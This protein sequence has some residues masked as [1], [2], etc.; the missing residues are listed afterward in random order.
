ML[1]DDDGE[2]KKGRGRTGTSGVSIDLDMT[3]ACSLILRWLPLTFAVVATFTDVGSR[4]TLQIWRIKAA[5]SFSP[6]SELP[7]TSIFE[8]HQP[9]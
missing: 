9:F 2:G 7:L 5:D 6:H 4:R 8:S 3:N 1:E